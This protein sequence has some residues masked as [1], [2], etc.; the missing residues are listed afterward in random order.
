MNTFQKVVVTVTCSL[1]AGLPLPSFAQES[2]T[3]DDVNAALDQLSCVVDGSYISVQSAVD[4]VVERC[5]DFTSEQ[6]CRR[7]FRRTSAKVLPAFKAL[8]RADLVAR[9]LWRDLR[10]ELRFAEDDTCLSIDDTPPQDPPASDTPTPDPT[11][12][13]Y[14]TEPP[15]GNPSRFPPQPRW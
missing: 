8:G 1:L 4:S 13:P 5:A 6:S 2:C 11:P 9:N 10:A 12:N 3:T 15:S 7:C 14:P